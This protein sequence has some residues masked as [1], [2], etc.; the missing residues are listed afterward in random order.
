M[1]STRVIEFSALEGYPA[2]YLVARLGGRRGLIVRNWEA[3]I[4]AEKPFLPARYAEQGGGRPGEAIR[5]A[6]KRELR[7]VARQMDSGL[8]ETF[9]RVFVYF[10]LGTLFSCIRYRARRDSGEE[11]RDALESSLLS[12]ALKVAI[13]EAASQ[14]QAMSAAEGAF[15]SAFGI[16]GENAEGGDIAE[17]EQRLTDAFLS[18]SAARA[19]HPVIRGFFRT[20]VDMRNLVSVYKRLR[21][22]IEAAPQVIEGG[23]ARRSRLRGISTEAALL[24]AIR[25]FTGLEADRPS[26][27]ENL[28]LK[29][30]LV[31]S[32]EAARN[33]GAVGSV[34]DYML[35]CHVEARN[36]GLIFAG[37]DLE[38]ELLR[39]EIVP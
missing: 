38:R 25:R 12:R 16:Y 30:L 2:D 19:R 18:D 4:M 36:L 26:E 23:S 8:R 7:W 29:R 31:Y 6:L 27:V 37:G 1:K 11:V 34:L 33:S 39:A 3:T 14:A 13:M 5:N 35:R 17:A 32:K 15:S 20:V 10:E 9:R 21:W 28:F 24:S 22:G